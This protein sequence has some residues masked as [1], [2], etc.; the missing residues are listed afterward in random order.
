M[1]LAEIGEFV[2][3]CFDPDGLIAHLKMGST[4]TRLIGLYGAEATLGSTLHSALG[5]SSNAS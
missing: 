5:Y 1:D 2:E 3:E 4:F